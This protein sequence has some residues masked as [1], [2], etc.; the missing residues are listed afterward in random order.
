MK[1]KKEETLPS[2]EKLNIKKKNY[3]WFPTIRSK[4]FD[5][6]INSIIIGDHE[7]FVKI[8]DILQKKE[9]NAKHS[10]RVKNRYLDF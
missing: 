2:Q 1:N 6:E 9:N 4:M 3:W 7:S 8:Y 5:P 10:L